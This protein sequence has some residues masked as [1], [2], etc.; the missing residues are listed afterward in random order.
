MCYATWETPGGNRDKR[1]YCQEVDPDEEEDGEDSDPGDNTCLPNELWVL[2]ARF[3]DGT[4]ERQ[5]TW[6][7]RSATDN[8]DDDWEREWED[9]TGEDTQGC[10]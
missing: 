3:P 10:F 8:E 6:R 2:N 5:N 1:L 7:G 9:Q 4:L